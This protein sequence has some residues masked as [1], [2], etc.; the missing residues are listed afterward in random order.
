[1]KMDLKAKVVSLVLMAVFVMNIFGSIAV[2]PYQTNDN[3]FSR[4]NEVVYAE[5]EKT[6]DEE[7]E[8]EVIEGQLKEIIN[9]LSSMG[10]LKGYDDG[11]FRPEATITRAEFCA[12][13]N[14]MLNLQDAVASNT[15]PSKFS[16]VPS[17]HWAKA[18]I[19]VAYTMGII[20]GYGD[21]RFGPD[22]YVTYEQVIK[23]LVCAI[24]YEAAAI[25]KGGYP[26]GYLVVAAQMGLLKNIVGKA[27][28]PAKRG[29]VATAVYNAINI[30]IPQQVITTTTTGISISSSGGGGG[31]GKGRRNIKEDGHDTYDGKGLVTANYYYTLYRSGKPGKNEV[32]IDGIVY[33]IGNTDIN[34]YVGYYVTFTYTVEK[35]SEKGTIQYFSID[36]NDILNIPAENIEENT[37]NQRIYYWANKE[38]D[39]EPKKANI[40][41]NVKIV[42]NNR[43]ASLRENIFKPSYGNIKLIDN[44]RDGIYDVA[45]INSYELYVVDSKSTTN[46]V[47]RT[48]YG[49][50]V[51]IPMDFNSNTYDLIVTKVDG[52]V[53]NNMSAI[54]EGDVISVAFSEN[55]TG[56][57]LIQIV[58]I[59]NKVSG[60]V[61]ER[62]DTHVY[63]GNK[64]YEAIPNIKYDGAWPQVDDTVELY[65]DN[66]NRIVGLKIIE[67]TSI[68]YL[69][70]MYKSTG[71]DENI[72]LK[73][74]S[75]EGNSLY[76]RLESD[77]VLDN[78]I[79]KETV[80]PAQL[81]EL[82][83]NGEIR[84]QLI[85][86]VT[87]SAGGK[88]KKIYLPV[89]NLSS[90]EER[91]ARFSLDYKSES[92]KF[93]KAGA[94]SYEADRFVDGEK[95]YKLGSNTKIIF[96][97]YGEAAKDLSK[98]KSHYKL[99]DGGYYNI[100]A[101]ELN[102]TDVIGI[103]VLK[104]TE[105]MPRQ[106]IEDQPLA[107]VTDISKAV[108][109]GRG[110]ITRVKYLQDGTEKT[111][112]AEDDT[113]VSNVYKGDIIQFSVDDIGDIDDVLIL[114]PDFDDPDDPDDTYDV[115]QALDRSVY[116]GEEKKSGIKMVYGVIT[117]VNNEYNYITVQFSDNTSENYM[118][119]YG[120][121]V[122]AWDNEKN[123]YVVSKKDILDKNKHQVVFMRAIE[124]D[125]RILDLIV[126]K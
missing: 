69:V 103:L 52:T 66:N 24:G 101:Y 16:D 60:V 18:D 37:T 3:F 64:S 14:R 108:V 11:T 27:G 71:V 124:S 22:D 68:A 123:K 4:G 53:L 90:V 112:Y 43:I 126:L 104:E 58:L 50:Q 39:D 21:G 85:Q 5:E 28:E 125:G 23:M 59:E 119:A 82:F 122:Y 35:S 7:K 115:Y 36:S 25:Q 31:G 78:G 105:N 95:Q 17:D 75:T 57:K 30:D 79:T 97:P 98:Y 8:K 34:D 9:K 100:E 80:T 87:K 41:S 40:A 13:V 116:T 20:K 2:I 10:I 93:V 62:D 121:N 111:I 86:Y 47:I 88:L 73:L 74:F 107:V 38:K 83:E 117:N 94:G 61:K 12:V 106:L 65:L 49:S 92:V 6:N 72:Q 109:T 67:Y 120:F 26:D 110:V 51:E 81:Y 118:T 113:V 48:K 54:S 44:N 114:T 99:V 96:V 19:N 45:Y 55:E 32:M 76:I 15:E 91:L 46:K 33:K 63:I 42:L 70:D 89:E 84:Q 29:L 77:I 102:A 56:K 1:M